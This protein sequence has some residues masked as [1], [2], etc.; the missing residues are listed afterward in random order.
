MADTFN[1]ESGD[2][3]LGAGDPATGWAALDAFAESLE[4]ADDDWVVT[5]QS[6][7][8]RQEWLRP[9]TDETVEQLRSDDVELLKFAFRW[10]RFALFGEPTMK[11]REGASEPRRKA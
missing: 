6:R 3:P 11:T 5:F 4:L 7:V 10:L 9:Y 1:L 8:G 2:I